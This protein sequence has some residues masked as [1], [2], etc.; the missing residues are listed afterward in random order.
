MPQTAE[1]LEKQII[2]TVRLDYL[3]HLPRSYA[4]NPDQRWPLILF[5]HGAGERGSD[6][7]LV[8]KH[9]IAKLAESDESFPFI[10]A[11]PQCP[12]DSLW[13]D[14][15]DALLALLDE[16]LA[17]YLVDA[18][19]VYLTGL[20]L[21]GYGAWNLAALHPGR[22]AAIAPFCG[23]AIP[24][25][26]FPARVCALRQVPVWAFHGA[27]D[28][29]VPVSESQSLV[30]ALQVCGGDAMLTVY[31]DAAH[32]SWTRTYENPELY[33]WFLSHRRHVRA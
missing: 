21:G 1:R 15:V 12:A 26:G 23:G 9:G 11:S 31:P 33:R 28:P 24:M 13:D 7:N 19:R 20:S 8:K 25:R 16:V 2:K 10:A 5:L 27:L 29:V 17:S 18:N 30:E 4:A 32:D 3:L 6:L 14:H 22:F